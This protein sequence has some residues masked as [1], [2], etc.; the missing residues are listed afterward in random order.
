MWGQYSAGLVLAELVTFIPVMGWCSWFVFRD[1]SSTSV[2]R[3][4]LVYGAVFL[5]CIVLGD[6]IATRCEYGFDGLLNARM[7]FLA[8]SYGEIEAVAWRSVFLVPM[9]AAMTL[10]R[11]GFGMTL[12]DIDSDQPPKRMRISIGKLLI[13]T[14]V[15]AV[16]ITLVKAIGMLFESQLIDSTFSNSDRLMM[17]IDLYLK[18]PFA[19]VVTGIIFYLVGLATT[20]RRLWTLLLMLA[21]S[22]SYG[23]NL[24]FDW[25]TGLLIPSAGFS[26]AP[27]A[28]RLLDA[29]A[30]VVAML[31]VFGCFRWAGL[32]V[33]FASRKNSQQSVS[34]TG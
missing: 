25:L 1:P 29:A 22:L 17:R 9:L 2:R 21:F 11:W 16:M 18:P 33:R 23:F 12:V 31:V 13:A 4:F 14:A 34:S 20:K 24:L 32:V 27:T 28:I 7:G 30:P 19:G 6:L 5:Y 15:V 3:K 8:I 26:P 10:V